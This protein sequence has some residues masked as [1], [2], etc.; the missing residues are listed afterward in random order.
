MMS[1]GC[2]CCTIDASDFRNSVCVSDG[3][4]EMKYDF[5]RQISAIAH[6]GTARCQPLSST[7]VCGL[8]RRADWRL[9]AA[10][11][12]AGGAQFAGQPINF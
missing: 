11:D 6:D 3:G 5:D 1:L 8:P 9:R 4:D 12:D 10:L 7:F 2:R